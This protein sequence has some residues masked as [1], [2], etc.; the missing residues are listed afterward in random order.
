MMHHLGGE[1]AREERC[2][3][4]Q[5]DAAAWAAN[6]RDAVVRFPFAGSCRLV[7]PGIIHQTSC[8]CR[9]RNKGAAHAVLDD[10]DMQTARTACYQHRKEL[11]AQFA[12][13][14]P[15]MLVSSGVTCKSERQW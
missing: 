14:Q 7:P 10:Q 2:A 3:A 5:L 6:R 13:A 1:V 9:T 8:N 4:L 15:V 11:S 12:C